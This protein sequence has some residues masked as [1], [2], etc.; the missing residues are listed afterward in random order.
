MNLLQPVKGDITKYAPDGIISQ[1]FN[2]PTT[3]SD[4]L[5]FY[6][7]L[8]LKG[9]NGI[10]FSG[11]RG[12]PIYAAHDGLV[13]ESRL[14]PNTF[15]KKISIQSPLINNKY[16][17]TIYAHNDELLVSEGENVSQG[18][19]IAKMGNSGSGYGIV[20][21]VHLHFGL[22]E[23]TDPIPNT[24]QLNFGTKSYTI[25]N[26]DNGFHGAIDPLPFLQT[27]MR[28]VILGKEQ[29]LLDDN[30]KIALNIGDEIELAKLKLRGLSGDPDPIYNKEFL[31]NYLIYPLVDRLRLKDLFGL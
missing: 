10:D 14:N 3:P 17:I 7:S 20:M 8:G 19:I 18:Q 5:A 6:K 12:T 26:E 29:F 22:Y 31:D 27:N 28:Y 25:I 16:F 30:L 23:A 9:H 11:V 24:F 15:G 21:G 13:I 2:D 1:K 4:L